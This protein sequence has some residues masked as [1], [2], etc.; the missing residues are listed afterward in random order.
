MRA[1]EHRASHI[2]SITVRKG[3]KRCGIHRLSSSR[4]NAYG[5][6]KRSRLIDGPARGRQ[7]LPP[8]TVNLPLNIFLGLAFV[9]SRTITEA[10]V[11]TNDRR[12]IA[13]ILSASGGQ[14]RIRI[15]RD[16]SHVCE[17]VVA[18][19]RDRLTGLSTNLAKAAT[20]RHSGLNGSR[21]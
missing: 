16:G 11:S 9:A 3:A 15:R 14:C 19:R 18:E 8:G 4:T 5:I 2:A 20:T 12:R 17:A 13:R 1:R 6:Q 7:P 21:S 10:A